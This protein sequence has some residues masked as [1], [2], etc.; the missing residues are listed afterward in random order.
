VLNLLKVQA[1]RFERTQI[2]TAV[3]EDSLDRPP[4]FLYYSVYANGQPWNAV[5]SRGKSYPQLRFISTKAAF[6]W[7]ALM[8]NDSYTSI[9]RKAVENLGNQNRG[10]LSGR[11]ENS[12]LG[13][14][15][16]IDVNTNAVILES[17]LYQARSGQPLAF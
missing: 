15:T 9:L 12:N 7:Q 10:Y 1:Q 5:S 11:Y 4:Y 16:A 17:L 2:L 6:A 3:N 8:P 13:V 14:N